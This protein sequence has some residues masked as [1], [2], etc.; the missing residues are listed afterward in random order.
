[1]GDTARENNY[2]NHLRTIPQF[3]GTCWF[4]SIINVMLYSNGFRNVLKKNFKGK[5]KKP[6][7]K[8]FNFLLYMLKNS[9]N[10][11]KMARVYDDFN[12]LSLKV[13]YLLISYL[14]KYDIEYYNSIK[15]VYSYGGNFQYINNILNSYNIKYLDIYYYKKLNTKSRTFSEA[16]LIDKDNKHT[17]LENLKDIDLLIYYHNIIP[18]KYDF[19]KMDDEA[20]LPHKIKLKNKL[21]F[22]K[23]NTYK[24][25]INTEKKI[26]L[27]D[28][29]YNLDCCLFGSNIIEDS[30]HVISGITCPN[31]NKYI[32]D[33]INNPISYNDYKKKKVKT[34]LNPCKPLL[35]D[36]TELNND[37][38]IDSNN[39][40]KIKFVKDKKNLCYN[41]FKGEVICIYV[42]NQDNDNDNDIDE[43]SLTS[44]DFKYDKKNISLLIKNNIYDNL[45]NYNMIELTD[46]INKNIT[47]YIN[48]DLTLIKKQP[49]EYYYLYE[50]LTNNKI[51]LSLDNYTIAKTI[52]LNII[53]SYLKNGTI[54][55]LYRYRNNSTI[56][57]YINQFLSKSI[58][59]LKNYFKIDEDKKT[60]DKIYNYL[61]IDN[62]DF[63]D[64]DIKTKEEDKL[65]KI[66]V[67]LIIIKKFY[68]KIKIEKII[69]KIINPDIR[70]R[71]NS[72]SSITKSSS[73]ITSKL[74]IDNYDNKL[75]EE[76]KS[77]NNS[78]ERSKSNKTKSSSL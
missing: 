11:E 41:L 23:N 73:V 53:Y 52:L 32:I 70:S 57:K 50:K 47:K 68:K 22:H 48:I 35:Y 27:G 13:E 74:D 54:Y 17:D 3:S 14:K 65:K 56:K 1:M 72:R 2:C 43:S 67:K 20:F 42:K 12:N 34:L 6:D 40:D 10:T 18:E 77:N 30:G 66:L 45:K 46:F 69:S 19:I 37:F 29:F 78:N 16:L 63:Y 21:N 33:S 15:E 4:N 64:R 59:E 60:L 9:N 28:Y 39:C 5:R 8:F 62:P 49:N 7:D 24:Q 26:K 55:L 71:S 25:I 51:D 38:C 75:E 31:D 61:F 58:E 44:H 76:M 36:W